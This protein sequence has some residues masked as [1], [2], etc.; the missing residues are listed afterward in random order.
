MAV[1]DTGTE[2][3]LLPEGIAEDLLRKGLR[4]PRLPVVNGSL[5]NAFGNKTKRIKRQALIEFEVDGFR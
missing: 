3:C 1:L 2:I 5:I 4:T